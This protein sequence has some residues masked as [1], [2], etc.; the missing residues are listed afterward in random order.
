[1]LYIYRSK[2]AGSAG[3]ADQ[4]EPISSEFPMARGNPLVAAKEKGN[5]LAN[6]AKDKG[7]LMKPKAK[8]Q[9]TKERRTMCHLKALQW[10]QEAKKL[11][12]A[13]LQ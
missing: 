5:K 6:K 2:S 3:S 4:P 10:A 13:A 12:L 9:T 1:M 7:K 11:I 8:K